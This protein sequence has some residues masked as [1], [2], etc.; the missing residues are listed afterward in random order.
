MS[1]HIV[2]EQSNI[3]EFWD[4]INEIVQSNNDYMTPSPV[5]SDL[6]EEEEEL[7]DKFTFTFENGNYQV[8]E[9]PYQQY[10]NISENK[11]ESQTFMDSVFGG[12][13]TIVTMKF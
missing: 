13:R 2:P 1:D 10:Y 8:Q 11:I 5:D 3:N 4:A 12:S 9:Y 6:K 7:Q